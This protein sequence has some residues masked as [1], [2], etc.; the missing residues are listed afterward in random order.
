MK[1]LTPWLRAE[2]YPKILAC[3]DVGVSLHSSS[4]GLDLP[5]KV[6]DMQ[7]CRL[8]VLAL[9]FDCISE[10]VIDGV[11]GYLFDDEQQLFE[12][13]KLLFRKY[14]E[15]QEL[16]RLKSV[17]ASRKRKTWDDAWNS[18]VWPVINSYF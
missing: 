2:D 13:L 7:G 14:P 3:A 12:N 4:S 18:N 1:I 15:N 10:L 11:N 17:C 16:I 6:V 5:M 9:E 8:P